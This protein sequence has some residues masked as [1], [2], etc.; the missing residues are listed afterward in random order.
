MTSIRI[1]SQFQNAYFCRISFLQRTEH[2]NEPFE[3]DSSYYLYYMKHGA[4]NN[5][6]GFSSCSGEE[7]QSQNNLRKSTA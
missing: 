2:K 5:S 6:F 7:G 3:N 4:V 1:S